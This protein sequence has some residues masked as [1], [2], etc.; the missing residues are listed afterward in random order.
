MPFFCSPLNQCDLLAGN[1]MNVPVLSDTCQMKSP[2]VIFN[3]MSAATKQR[4]KLSQEG[5]CI[6][7]LINIS[8]IKNNLPSEYKTNPK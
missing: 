8:I 4:A 1:H 2:V 7:M 6:P 5:S 3:N